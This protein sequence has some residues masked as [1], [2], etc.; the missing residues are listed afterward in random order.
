MS[1]SLV[2]VA[3]PLLERFLERVRSGRTAFPLTEMGLRAHGLGPLVSSLG[4]L[5]T[6]GAAGTEVL[7]DTLLAERGRAKAVPPELVWTGPEAR[8]SRARDTEVVLAELLGSARRSVLIA[9]FS[10]DHGAR[11]LAPLHHVMREH[12]VRCALFAEDVANFVSENWPFGEPFPTLYRDARDERYTSMHAKCVVVDDARVLVT[13][14]NFTDRGQ[15]RNIEVGVLLHDPEFA[16]V[17]AAQWMDAVDT[18]YF[19]RV[20]PASQR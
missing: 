18:G 2:Q 5:N 16:Q 9:G 20:G 10:F 19:E 1:F 17:L 14:A 6:L 8:V 13:S 3:T 12:G 4:T 7:L 15:T 11:L